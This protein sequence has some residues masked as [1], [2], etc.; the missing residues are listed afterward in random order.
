VGI[1][2]FLLWVVT[3]CSFVMDINFLEEPS[4]VFFRVLFYAEHRGSRFL[5][6]NGT[7]TGATRLHTRVLSCGSHTFKDNWIGKFLLEDLFSCNQESVDVLHKP[8]RQSK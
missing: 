4:A 2:L 1:K 8:E 6:N 7:H 5:S 3:P